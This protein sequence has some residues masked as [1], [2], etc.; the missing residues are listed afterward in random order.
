MSSKPIL[1]D[2]KKTKPF[3]KWAGGK[4]QLISDID[5]RLPDKLK[6][7]KIKKYIEPFIGG[8]AVFFHVAQ[9]YEGIEHFYLN[10]AN[11]D[12]ANSY[13]IIKNKVEELISALQKL[14]TSYL[15]RSEV[16]RSIFYYEIRD[17]YNDRSNRKPS[18]QKTA[19]LLFLN[20]TCFNGLYRVN[21]KGEFNVPFGKYKNPA[22]CNPTNLRRVS[23]LLQNAVI[24]CG[25]FE[26]CLKVIDKKSFVYFDPPY[27]PIS[28]TASFTSY[29]QD[30]FSE[31]DQIRLVEFCKK[32]HKKGGKFLLSNS[33][34]KNEDPK[35]HFFED[36]YSDFTIERVKASRAINCKGEKRGQ[37]NEI[38]AR[39]Y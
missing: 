32:I 33:D 11:K 3:L 23:D 37:I 2:I 15:A 8:G 31:N 19:H 25:D 13:L 27:R 6:K 7:G 12:L 4:G 10:D 21:R 9:N 1:L 34:P 35:D 24:T 16:D 26:N 5:Q 28:K 39:N 17:K 38:I 18:V 22:I 30:D 14:Q 36:H 29:A 20:R